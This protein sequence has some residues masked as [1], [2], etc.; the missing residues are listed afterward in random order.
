MNTIW[1]DYVQS[2]HTLYDSRRLRFSDRF[3]AQF[4]PLFG[5]PD[6]CRVLEIGCGP[7]A[8]AE[9]LTRWYP[10]A[11]VTGLDRDS[12]FVAFAQKTVPQ[13]QFLEGDAAA[14]P[15]AEESFDVTISNTVAE[16]IEPSAFYGEQ[17]RVLKPGG[18]CLVLCCRRGV[19][20]SA[21]C[22]QESDFEQ[23]IWERVDVFYQD[24]VQKNAIGAYAQN[25]MELPRRMEQYGF[26]NVTSSYAITALTPDDPSC[27][28]EM[29]RAIIEAGRHAAL[30]NID[31]LL[32][33]PGHPVT[34]AEH[35]EIKRRTNQRFDTRLALYTAGEKQW[36]TETSLIQVVR[37]VK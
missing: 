6:C 27:S 9:T 33:L 17:Y 7:G 1:S 24:V 28:P 35:D 5:L 23:A 14:L 21:P 18:V 26:R 20:L 32:L 8:L 3:R 15:F 37:G 2:V 25:E 4:E 16:H 22:L 13:A 12:R 31:S 34:Q 30:D 19:C 10:D 36:D 29:A 11:A